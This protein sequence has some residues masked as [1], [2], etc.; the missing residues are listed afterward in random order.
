MI[1]WMVLVGVFLT[2][3]VFCGYIFQSNG[4][5]NFWDVFVAAVGFTFWVGGFI[6]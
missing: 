1:D 2:T 5:A 6:L 4:E 3:F